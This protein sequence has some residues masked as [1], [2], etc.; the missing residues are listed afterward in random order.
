VEAIVA[1]GE[2]RARAALV[3][4]LAFLMTLL[5]SGCATTD[6]E[7]DLAQIEKSFS[8][9]PDEYTDAQLRLGMM[10]F[11]DG[12]AHELGAAIGDA[13]LETHDL[14][15]LWALQAIYVEALTSLISI[16]TGPDAEINLLDMLVHM[17]LMRGALEDFWIPRHLGPLGSPILAVA[18]MGEQKIWDLSSPVMTPKQQE[19]LRG[20]IRHWRAQNPDRRGVSAKR[21]THFASEF[22]A[23]EQALALALLQEVQGV[24][25]EARQA[26]LSAERMIFLVEHLPFQL[27]AQLQLFV[28]QTRMGGDT[29][30][31]IEGYEQLAA[32]AERVSL[33]VA[34]MPAEL[35]RQRRE[36]LG[37]FWS[38]LAAERE[39]LLTESEEPLVHVL[40]ELRQTVEASNQLVDRSDA[41]A[42]RFFPESGRDPDQEPFDIVPY[43]E[44]AVQV[45]QAAL[46][47]E[48]LVSAATLL[49][50]SE[51]LEA[52][53]APL[54]AALTQ[55]T[56]A[57]DRS[58]MRAFWLG[59]GLIAAAG[60]TALLVALT[61]RRLSIRS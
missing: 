14:N 23:E 25:A 44:T 2:E 4:A 27:E 48:R 33:T 56:E 55:A 9:A 45:T 12:H 8:E 60:V 58:V 46:Q 43:R 3:L 16:A 37:D 7:S 24:A 41:L 22:V 18:K 42:A 35:E 13:K 57:L 36:A 6:S 21:F 38:G 31:L 19:E 34:A 59:I 28:Y 52:G 32:A 26:R 40:A 39:A 50:G 54:A 15:T 49:V 53:G 61:Y 20:L 30:T 10:R 1:D 11:A 5:L 51:D 17:T 47:L 29:R